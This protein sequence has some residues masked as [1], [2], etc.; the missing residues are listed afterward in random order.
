ML[1]DHSRT[2]VPF[3]VKN[4]RIIFGNSLPDRLELEPAGELQADLSVC[5]LGLDR[6]DL[7]RL[8]SEPG[9]RGVRVHLRLRGPLQREEPPGRAVDGL[10]DG[11]HPV[12][13]QDDGLVPAERPADPVALLLIEYDA[14][15]VV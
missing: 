6:I 3:L 15:V 4:V 12:V 1:C 11:E 7:D 9:R 2:G 8:L 13:A 10:A 14:A 5:A